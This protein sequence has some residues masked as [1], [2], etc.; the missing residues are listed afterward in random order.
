[1]ALVR[2]TSSVDGQS[3]VWDRESR[4]VSLADQRR[5]TAMAEAEDVRIQPDRGLLGESRDRE[6]GETRMSGSTCGGGRLRP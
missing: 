4:K 1:M 2:E 5:D 6:L 3:E